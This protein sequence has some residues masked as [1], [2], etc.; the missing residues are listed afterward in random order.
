[1][2]KFIP[3]EPSGAQS[4]IWMNPERVSAVIQN[5]TTSLVYIEGSDGPIHVLRDAG[6]LVGLL[7]E[8]LQQADVLNKPQTPASKPRKDAL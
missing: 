2:A 1:M 5:G 4:A 3:I 7:Q 8:T 6:E